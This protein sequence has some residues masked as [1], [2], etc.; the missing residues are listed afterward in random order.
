MSEILNTFSRVS[1]SFFLN[2]TVLL[3]DLTTTRL[4]DTV[5][6]LTIVKSTL[7][8][9][10]NNATTT[11]TID[12]SEAGGVVS[13]NFLLHA[14]TTPLPPSKTR[15]Q[16]GPPLLRMNETNAGPKNVGTRSGEKGTNAKVSGKVD[17]FDAFSSSRATVEV[18]GSSNSQEPGNTEF[19]FTEEKDDGMEA[20]RNKSN[21]NELRNDN[22]GIMKVNSTKL[23]NSTSK[24][25][26]KV[27]FNGIKES[28]EIIEK[29]TRLFLTKNSS[30]QATSKDSSVTKAASQ[31]LTIGKTTLKMADCL[32]GSRSRCVKAN[33]EKKSEILDKFF[34]LHSDDVRVRL[35]HRLA[36]IGRAA[37]VKGN[38]LQSKKSKAV[39]GKGFKDGISD[40]SAMEEKMKED[41]KATKEGGN[42]V[43]KR[44]RNSRKALQASKET[45]KKKNP[46]EKKNAMTYGNLGIVKRVEKVDVGLND[47]GEVVQKSRHG[48][49][50]NDSYLSHL[51]RALQNSA[52][53]YHKTALCSHGNKHRNV[54]PRFG[55]HSGLIV[56]HGIVKNLD[57]CIKYCCESHTCD[58]AMLVKKECFTITC[59][60]DFHCQFVPN[61][62]HRRTEAVRIYRG[63]LRFKALLDNENEA[64]SRNEAKEVFVKHKNNHRPKIRIQKEAKSKEWRHTTHKASSST[65]FIDAVTN[66]TSMTHKHIALTNSLHMKT[67]ELPNG[68]R[69]ENFEPQSNNEVPLNGH[70]NK[71]KVEGLHETFN[72]RVKFNRKETSPS[73]RRKVKSSTM[74]KP[75]S[76]SSATNAPTPTTR[77]PA[78]LILLPVY[79]SKNSTHLLN[80]SSKS[81]QGSSL[82][83]AFNSTFLS[84]FYA[85][86]KVGFKSYKAI[87]PSMNA[88]VLNH[89]ID[90]KGKSRVIEKQK[91][92]SYTSK[93]NKFPAKK[94]S[95][96]K[97]RLGRQRKKSSKYDKVM[98]EEKSKHVS[99]KSFKD[100]V[101]EFMKPRPISKPGF[102][103]L[104]H[105][106]EPSTLW[107]ENALST[108][109]STALAHDNRDKDSMIDRRKIEVIPLDKMDRNRQLKHAQKSHSSTESG[110][111]ESIERPFIS[112]K[113]LRPMTSNNDSMPYDTVQVY[114]G[115]TSKTV[116]GRKRG[117]MPLLSSR[118]TVLSERSRS[119]VSTTSSRILSEKSNDTNHVVPSVA[120][121]PLLSNS[122]KTLSDG[123]EP[124]NNSST[125][126]L[127]N[128]AA[129]THGSKLEAASQNLSSVLKEKQS[130]KIPETV[131]VKNISDDTNLEIVQE[132][133]PNSVANIPEEIKGKE[134]NNSI[135]MATNNK[136]LKKSSQE[137]YEFHNT[138]A[139]NTETT[140]EISK[141]KQRNSSISMTNLTSVA[142]QSFLKIVNSSKREMMRDAAGKH[143]KTANEDRGEGS[144][145]RDSKLLNTTKINFNGNET[146]RLTGKTS[147][148]SMGSPSVRHRVDTG[149]DS[150]GVSLVEYQV[151]TRKL[152]PATASS[153]IKHR[154]VST[155]QKIISDHSFYGKNEKN[156]YAASRVMFPRPEMRPTPKAKITAQFKMTAFELSKETSSQ[157]NKTRQSQLHLTRSN[158]SIHRGNFS[159]S[160]LHGMTTD[161]S[162]TAPPR[163]K[164]T[165]T[166]GTVVTNPVSTQLSKAAFEES[167]ANGDRN[168][169]SSQTRPIDNVHSL[170]KGLLWRQRGTSH[171]INHRLNQEMTSSNLSSASN[172]SSLR[173]SS[174]AAQVEKHGPNETKTISYSNGHHEIGNQTMYER[175]TKPKGPMMTTSPPSS[176]Q[177]IAKYFK[178]IGRDLEG[179]YYD[180][181]GVATENRTQSTNHVSTDVPNP[182]FLPLKSRN[183]SKD[184]EGSNAQTQSELLDKGASRSS[185][186]ASRSSKNSTSN[187]S[188]N[189]HGKSQS[190]Q[191]PDTAHAWDG[192]RERNVPKL[193]GGHVTNEKYPLFV[194]ERHLN[195]SVKENRTISADV[196]SKWHFEKPSN[197]TVKSGT[198]TAYNSQGEARS[199]AYVGSVNNRSASAAKSASSAYKNPFILS[200]VYS[201]PPMESSR[202]KSHSIKSSASVHPST[203]PSTKKHFPVASSTD[204]NISVKS[205]M[206]KSPT[207]RSSTYM[208]VYMKSST[209]KIKPTAVSNRN[210]V[211]GSTKPQRSQP[212]NATHVFMTFAK[213][214]PTIKSPRHK[215]VDMKS[216]TYKAKPTAVSNRN[217]V[218]GSTKP[219]RS[220]ALNATQVFMTFAKNNPTIKSPRHKHVDTKS[221]TYK[222]KP[223]VVSNRNAV[224]GSTKP[225]QSQA[226]N[227]THVFIS[228]T[229]N[230]PTIKSPRHKH[231]DTKSSTY[232][233]KPAVVSNRNAVSGSTKPHQSQAW[234]TTQVFMTFAKKSPITKSPRHKHVDMKSST[235]KIKPTAVSN[236]N[237]VSG[238][239]KPKQSQ[240]LNATHVFMTFAKNNP[241]IKSPRHKHV[242]T[243]SSTYKTKPAVV[244]NR[245][246]VSGS[247]KPQ[248]SQALNAT[249]VFISFTKKNSTVK[250]PRH[251]RVYTK[252][253]TYKT[254]PT[255]VSN[256]NAVSS[257]T[258]PHQSQPLN[259]THVF[260]TFAKKNPTIKSPR[261]QH[262]DTKSSTYKTKP[263]VVSNRNAV[264]GSTKPKQSQALNAT[265]ALMTFA[266]KNSTA[267]S[268][269]HKH[270]DMKSSTY[271]AKPTAVSNRNA[272]SG[273]TKPRLSQSINGT[274]DL[275]SFAMKNQ[276]INSSTYRNTKVKPSAYKT[277]PSSASDSNLTYGSSNRQQSQT[278]NAVHT[279]MTSSKNNHTIKSSAYQYFDMQT[280]SHKTKSNAISNANLT[281]RSTNQQRTQASNST[282]THI[283]MNY[284]NKSAL[285][286]SPK[287]PLQGGPS[288]VK[289]QSAVLNGT[290]EGESEGA[291]YLPEYYFP[292]RGYKHPTSKITKRPTNQSSL[293]TVN[294]FA[295]KR[296]FWKSVPGQSPY[297]LQYDK[298]ARNLSGDGFHTSHQNAAKALRPRLTVAS[299]DSLW[300]HD[301]SEDEKIVTEYQ[302]KSSSEQEHQS[303]AKIKPVVTPT[304]QRT[305]KGLSQ[306]LSTHYVT[307]NRTL[308]SQF[309]L[310]VERNDENAIE[311]AN[312][313]EIKHQA[314]DPKMK[315]LTAIHSNSFLHFMQNRSQLKTE[316]GSK[317]VFSED[318]GNSS[319]II[320][321]ADRSKTNA[322][323]AI[324]Q[325]ATQMNM[326]EQFIDLVHKKLHPDVTIRV[327]YKLGKKGHEIRTHQR[328]NHTS[329]ASKVNIPDT[330]RVYYRQ[331]GRVNKTN[332]AKERETGGNL[333]ESSHLLR[334]NENP[335][336]FISSN[337][338]SQI[339]SQRKESYHVKVPDTIKVYYNPGGY[340][341]PTLPNSQPSQNRANSVNLTEYYGIKKLYMHDSR[342]K[343]DPD[344]VSEIPSKIMKQDTEA[345][346]QN[347][348]MNTS[349]SDGL[350]EETEVVPISV[351]V[352]TI[353]PKSENQSNKNRSAEGNSPTKSEFNTL[354]E[355]AK[356]EASQSKDG[357]SQSSV[358]VSAGSKKTIAQ[359]DFDDEASVT[360]KHS[361]HRKAP[362]AKHCSLIG[363]YTDKMFRDG[364]R[365]GNFY[366]V[367]FVKDPVHCHRKCCADRRCNF[368]MFYREFCYLVECFSVRSCKLVPSKNRKRYPHLLAKIREPET[369]SLSSLFKTP[370]EIGLAHVP[371]KFIRP[372]EVKTVSGEKRQSKSQKLELLDLFHKLL[373]QLE[374]R[375]PTSKRGH[376]RVKPHYQQAI[377]DSGI[378]SNDIMALNLTRH[379]I[380]MNSSLNQS[381]PRS[382]EVPLFSRPFFGMPLSEPI[383]K[384][385]N[386]SSENSH[387][388]KL[389][390]HLNG[391]FANVS[392]P[393]RPTQS[394][395]IQILTQ[396]RIKKH[397]TLHS[398]LL[399][400]SS[401][402]IKKTVADLAARLSGI[403]LKLKDV[404]P[405]LK[406]V[407][408]HSRS[409][410]ASGDIAK[411]IFDSV[412]E[413]RAKNLSKKLTQISGSVE[414]NG[415]EKSEGIFY[416][417]ESQQHVR[418][419]LDAAS[420]LKVLAKENQASQKKAL[421][422]SHA[423]EKMLSSAK[424][425]KKP[426]VAG[427]S[428]L[429]CI[430]T[431]IRGGATLFGG[432]R[433]GV[434]TSHGGG[435]GLDQCI[436]R[437]CTGEDCHVALLVA[438]HCYTVKCYTA[439]LCRIVP[440]KRAGRYMMTVAYVRRSV[441]YSTGE[442]GRLQTSIASHMLPGNAIVCTESVVYEGFTLKGGYDA[443]HFTFKGEVGTLADCVELC[444]NAEFCDLVFMVTN[445]CYLVYCYSKDGCQHVKAYHG[446]LYRTRIAY[447]HSRRTIIPPWAQSNIELRGVI[448]SPN[449][450]ANDSLLHDKRKT[451]ILRGLQQNT[452]KVLAHLPL[453]T[454]PNIPT[455]L[456]SKNENLQSCL[457]TVI[458]KKTTLAEGHRAGKLLFRGRKRSD[459]D[460]VRDCCLNSQC[461]VAFIVGNYCFNVI[462]KSQKSCRPIHAAN[463][464]HSIRLAVIR[465][466]IEGENGKSLLLLQ[467]CY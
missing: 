76:N 12:H 134:G 207:V 381:A 219:Q 86:P 301:A 105:V 60:S 356:V 149:S 213:N 261:Q 184:T 386:Q 26:M 147:V 394:G 255:A 168:P 171:V 294:L 286:D 33:N 212:L 117:E 278:A 45:V 291:P 459:K 93:V 285:Q 8:K 70:S 214:N 413:L 179:E 296:L 457:R 329:A 247:T 238:S 312:L 360:P 395:K 373:G 316:N 49:T 414:K 365:A 462:C 327:H 129:V 234:N 48:S 263:T 450:T 283:L 408:A 225:Q 449:G 243:K 108:V 427:N 410:F 152:Q 404:L 430:V 326:T 458:R 170:K 295:L 438:G 460:C 18:K 280:S 383:V 253:S 74:S 393:F 350:S 200:T 246:A 418:K 175:A 111:D 400:K 35:A 101:N 119:R 441:T 355:N 256:R 161:R 416:R 319:V 276:S 429:T 465:T 330:I 43:G 162:T 59:K 29:A 266:T 182:Y 284:T 218:S 196:H 435:L 96:S 318:N 64:A 5:H 305:S 61:R 143:E 282:Q 145:T 95:K 190:L 82:N 66:V 396:N 209:Y 368:A 277:K 3:T 250:S 240:A 68:H 385:T 125:Q 47:L 81:R 24:N 139:S 340:M 415:T 317:R 370:P 260:M 226:L 399:R 308:S 345:S 135:R 109:E 325:P 303:R 344:V 372:K 127:S 103:A 57:R 37:M 464:K 122:L 136:H 333:V 369:R 73:D 151:P 113:P 150:D 193:S 358:K 220:Q 165:S 32:N 421:K 422:A 98:A 159:S 270:V 97:A 323:P 166:E 38:E 14:D 362:D 267:K 100:M 71:S 375:Q 58:L 467:S 224:S 36:E 382:K 194:T 186:S 180:A 178:A 188:E 289:I 54:I 131:L 425:T 281:S 123:L 359:E 245:N 216:S 328:S 387:A 268:P 357:F 189:G 233:T 348:V 353:Y 406:Y 13:Y 120:S 440:M 23:Q 241:T 437:C 424:D 236:R 380:N 153:R 84:K 299:N 341:Y 163:I 19:S 138:E 432:P 455:S 230:N 242:D 398:A 463:A 257:S 112:T 361:F 446:V 124:R 34:K 279:L 167:N 83:P 91:T 31:L 445:Q 311:H 401:S 420:N 75:S 69:A 237:A 466:S 158:P 146:T 187:I 78:S 452:G 198:K 307:T 417:K 265:H 331:G 52:P 92:R 116:T 121:K 192:K 221:S 300:H 7:D 407:L 271:N 337:H 50:V 176:K 397:P 115:K 252:S 126:N 94:N 10:T 443:G 137:L 53:K 118:S 156:L 65:K 244:S 444:C 251:Q 235:Y 89:K 321:H 157:D 428:K 371:T 80:V 309:N 16:I 42:V 436:E 314:I 4:N 419:E 223:A 409:R 378:V 384:E 248:Q 339:E 39:V 293:S 334:A 259:A 21:M 249:H 197:V 67:S 211:S 461:N 389:M 203:K 87:L 144:H 56:L 313:T 22:K 273:S 351:A 227:A 275:I 17:A 172:S 106:K 174:K 160:A 392:V 391:T 405:E 346:M 1:V 315:Q 141:A 433:A 298:L 72:R 30:L 142:V 347:I 310:S 107:S 290:S 217:A 342:S 231:V 140:E 215:H 453:I 130:T 41:V 390:N 114:V 297:W 288:N 51:M 320:Q 77:K 269:R 169:A 456:L 239:T 377:N 274:H 287:S 44:G 183:V 302:E 363:I 205:S 201:N 20:Y 376:V 451:I 222:T 352:S 173:G 442:Q 28:T 332:V 434:F 367:L 6:H 229:K 63:R 349:K 366:P 262:V 99:E 11:K 258:K 206:N 2:F 133:F 336:G 210:A 132:S 306:N 128:P 191:R 324:K 102:D 388:V 155:S 402:E 454:L 292:W 423:A 154:N 62:G 379:Y 447:L 412:K 208:H 164:L 9:E 411:T 448:Q 90:V 88:T 322:Q 264:S 204:N 46:S 439:R 110:N 177:T 181:T 195:G 354:H 403:N 185:N 338:S 202:N 104:I 343:Y 335:D 85:K 79:D 148:K 25:Q 364:K 199:A 304:S 55:L 254:K 228:F 374:K 272:V 15:D 232:K 426:E 431:S 40:V 27:S